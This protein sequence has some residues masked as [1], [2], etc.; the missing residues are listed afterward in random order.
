MYYEWFIWNLWWKLQVFCGFNEIKNSNLP[1]TALTGWKV[2]VKRG[3]LFK[4]GVH[5][6]WPRGSRCDSFHLRLT[7][8]LEHSVHLCPSVCQQNPNPK[9]RTVDG[10]LLFIYGCCYV[11]PVLHCDIMLNHL[12]ISIKV[13]CK[14]SSSAPSQRSSTGVN[15]LRCQYIWSCW[16]VLSLRVGG[17]FSVHDTCLPAGSASSVIRTAEKEKS[18]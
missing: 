12:T 9:L 18:V 1:A 17:H 3:L 8:N 4:S 16:W 5:D 10:A 14:L 6:W 7:E 13:W 11:M 2:K 15:V